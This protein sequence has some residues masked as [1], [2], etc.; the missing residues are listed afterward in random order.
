M[1]GSSIEQKG[2]LMGLSIELS[3]VNQFRALDIAQASLICPLNPSPSWQELNPYV[4]SP[5][6]PS[7]SVF[8]LVHANSKPRFSCTLGLNVPFLNYIAS[9]RS[10]MGSG[11]TI[12][13]G[14]NSQEHT[15]LFTTPFNDNYEII[16]KTLNTNPLSPV[17]YFTSLPAGYL[18]LIPSP[19]TTKD[20][21]AGS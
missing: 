19:L 12:R 9:L 14:G 8:S 10:R 16:N 13:V 7:R 17:C 3:V 20:R 4:S 6:R 2:T 15:E 21:N 18:H 1:E 11:P 5:D